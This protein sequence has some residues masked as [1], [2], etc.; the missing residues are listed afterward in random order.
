MCHAFAFERCQQSFKNNKQ[1]YHECCFFGM[2][3]NISYFTSR[4]LR[5]DVAVEFCSLMSRLA[6]MTITFKHLLNSS[7]YTLPVWAVCEDFPV[8]ARVSSSCYVA[9]MSEANT[10]TWRSC[11]NAAYGLLGVSRWWAPAGYV[12]GCAAWSEW[13]LGFCFLYGSWPGE[14][15]NTFDSSF[16][17]RPRSPPL[18]TRRNDY[19][20]SYCNV[21]TSGIL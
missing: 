19:V 13:G 1:L 7:A 12:C 4:Q 15:Y 10:H 11:T 3:S 17:R 14:P 20:P 18:L 9:S 16:F 21:V 5:L 6:I 8:V 2:F